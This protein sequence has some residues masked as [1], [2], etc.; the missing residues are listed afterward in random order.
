MN[1]ISQRK[2]LTTANIQTTME[3]TSIN[4]KNHQR[5]IDLIRNKQFEDYDL[6]YKSAVLFTD[7]EGSQW[8]IEYHQ[9][10]GSWIGEWVLTIDD[11]KAD[12]SLEEFET[13]LYMFFSDREEEIEEEKDMRNYEE[14][15]NELFRNYNYGMV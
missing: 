7:E 9:E 10:K 13:G 14:H 8:A 3:K 6:H 2:I 15:Q 5:A 4:K 1:A 11:N 12:V